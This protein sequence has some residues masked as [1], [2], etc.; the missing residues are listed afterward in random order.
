MN[1]GLR[2]GSPA[3][4]A[5]V[6]RA[7]WPGAVVVTV[8]GGPP[9]AIASMSQLLY[10]GNATAACEGLFDQLVSSLGEQNSASREPA[11]L[12][13]MKSP[14]AASERWSRWCCSRW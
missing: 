6:T 2:F 11:G 4:P 9:A 10:P 14:S 3:V 5:K 13:W 1:A 8:A 12:T 7:F